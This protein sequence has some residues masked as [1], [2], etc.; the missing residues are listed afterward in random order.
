MHVL[1]IQNDILSPNIITVICEIWSFRKKQK[2]LVK[3][4][5]I[6]KIKMPNHSYLPSF[7]TLV[8]VVE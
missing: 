2:K 7:L 4:I 1:F 5:N 3:R 6:F 8:L